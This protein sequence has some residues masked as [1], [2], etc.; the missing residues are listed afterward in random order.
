MKAIL[1]LAVIAAIALFSW[2][3]VA[4]DSKYDV[5]L[6]GPSASGSAPAN[7]NPGSA[8]GPDLPPIGQKCHTVRVCVSVSCTAYDSEG[9]CTNQACVAWED[10]FVCD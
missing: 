8:S 1:K 2:F 4:E 9:K 7:T 10:R 6:S 5:N 3:A